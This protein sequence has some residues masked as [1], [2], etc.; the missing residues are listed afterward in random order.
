MTELETVEAVVKRLE[1]KLAQ[2]EADAQ[3]YVKAHIFW[4]VTAAALIVG[5]IAGHF[6]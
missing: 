6:I 2:Y 1:E 4:I 3:G 5:A